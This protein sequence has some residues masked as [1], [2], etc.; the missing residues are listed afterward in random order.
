MTL[1]AS[2]P[3]ERSDMRG[4]T[5]PRMSPRSYGLRLL[6]TYAAFNLRAFF[7]RTGNLLSTEN[8]TFSARMMVAIVSKRG[9]AP[10]ASVL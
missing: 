2:S 10:G 7:A 4:W 6:A 8:P 1:E 9:L 3:H 5:S